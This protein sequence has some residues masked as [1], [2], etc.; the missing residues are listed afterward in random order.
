MNEQIVKYLLGLQG[1]VFKLLPMREAE[2]NGREPFVDEYLESLIVNVSGALGTY[3]L[4]G[5]Q[6]KYLWVVNSLQYLSRVYV[7]FPR[8]RTIIL[9]TVTTI[10]DLVEMFGGKTDG[11]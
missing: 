2:E 3:P 8:W 5:E 6:K 9:N 4:L 7:T 1:D 11:K 10:G